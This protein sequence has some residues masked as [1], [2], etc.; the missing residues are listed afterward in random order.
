MLNR[1]LCDDIQNQGR[2]GGDTAPIDGH[3][4]TWGTGKGRRGASMTRKCPHCRGTT[5][6]QA[7]YGP[8]PCHD[9]VGG[10]LNQFGIE[11]RAKVNLDRILKGI[12]P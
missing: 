2:P 12:T 11:I 10:Y 5:M 3:R 4:G 1:R 7:E 8:V 9:C 6:I